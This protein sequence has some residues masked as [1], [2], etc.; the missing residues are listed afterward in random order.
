MAD[1]AAVS[2]ELG[3]PVGG[4]RGRLRLRRQQQLRLAGLGAAS[5]ALYS[6]LANMDGVALEMKLTGVARAE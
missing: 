4:D 6:Q 1:S 5:G 3:D 2:D